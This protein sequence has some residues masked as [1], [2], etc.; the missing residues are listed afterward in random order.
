MM[1]YVVFGLGL[2]LSAAG[3]LSIYAGYDIIQVERGWT[4]VIAGT[5]AL[6][7]GIVTISLGLIL[8]RLQ[9][10]F[11]LFEAGLPMEPVQRFDA[12]P[13][14]A[15][16]PMATPFP[17]KPPLPTAPFAEP[18][19]EASQITAS[20]I[21]A[22]PV[23]VPPIAVSSMASIEASPIAASD[24]E[25]SPVV[26]AAAAVVPDPTIVPELPQPRVAAPLFPKPN[27]P[28]IVKPGFFFASSNE[29]VKTSAPKPVPLDEIDDPISDR[30]VA[31]AQAKDT[32]LALSPIEAPEP[33]SVRPRS[34]ASL[35]LDEMWKRV[36]SE[37]DKPIFPP[38]PD[39]AVPLV[40]ETQ[41]ETEI[42]AETSYADDAS[43]ADALLA[44]TSFAGAITASGLTASA[45]AS[46][47]PKAPHLSSELLP[48]ERW[49]EP[50]GIVHDEEAIHVSEHPSETPPA[51]Q[52]FDD[53]FGFEEPPK[54]RFDA[55][56]NSNRALDNRDFDAA[57]KPRD[58]HRLD[59]AEKPLSSSFHPA[60][61]LSQ[62]PVPEP[63]VI[64]RYEAEGTAYLMFSDGSIEAQSEA[65]VF[66]FASMAELKTFIES[67][68]AAE[69]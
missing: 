24:L 56:W 25:T 49:N 30:S 35:S 12:E 18:P 60:L 3:S 34:S 51:E 11:R 10:L 67:K 52:S 41:Q 32:A 27:F 22:S 63:S 45:L 17:V 59:Y 66:H 61:D 6:S 69:P 38:R 1:N 43:L 50:H 7:G 47:A 64:G 20:P 68:Q 42:E 28:S 39:V 2:L 13:M 14:L 29:P 46:E 62:P 19:I 48:A 16:A 5:T 31:S 9:S 36:S 58:P 40:Q 54:N 44:D 4:E 15:T 8:G 57:H 37:I 23:A 33:E 26:E 53:G 65:G 21:A 55:A